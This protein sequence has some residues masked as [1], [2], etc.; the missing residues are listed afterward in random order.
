MFIHLHLSTYRALMTFRK[1]AWSKMGCI[2][3]IAA[4]NKEVRVANLQHHQSDGSWGLS[5]K[6]DFILGE[7]VSRIFQGRELINLSWSPSGQE[8]LVADVHGRLSIFQVR[9]AINRLAA[10]KSWPPESDNHLNALVGIMWLNAKGRTVSYLQRFSFLAYPILRF[11]STAQLQKHLVQGRTQ[12]GAMR[13]FHKKLRALM[14]HGL[15]SS[16]KIS[17]LLLSLLGL[18]TQGLYINARTTNGKT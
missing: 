5:L 18:A 3:Y 4:D 8:L 12:S 16:I 1:I 9:V 11:H 2:A 6:S 13:P 7:H 15:R 14:F 10:C 17:W